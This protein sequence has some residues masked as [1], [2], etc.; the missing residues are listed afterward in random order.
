MAAAWP[1]IQVVKTLSPVF[2]LPDMAIRAVVI[3]LAVGFVPAVILSWIFEW[4]PEGFRRDS[5]LTAAA[6]PARKRR[7]GAAIIAMLSPLPQ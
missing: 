4:M 5:E 7:F 1:L 3:V 2:G 6:P